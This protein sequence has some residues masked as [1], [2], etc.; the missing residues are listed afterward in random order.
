[1][2]PYKKNFGY[3][4]INYTAKAQRAQRKLCWIKRNEKYLGKALEISW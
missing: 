1:M 4:K 3:N 2:F